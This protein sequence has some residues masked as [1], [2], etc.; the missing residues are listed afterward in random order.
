MLD[1]MPCHHIIYILC[2]VLSCC[3][4]SCHHG[5]DCTVSLGEYIAYMDSASALSDDNPVYIFETLVD[6]PRFFTGLR[7]SVRG[8]HLP[9]D[10]GD[11]LS[12]VRI[13]MCC[14]LLTA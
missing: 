9:G 2:H 6:V 1:A 10:R 7:H 3:V 12:E 8:C 5:V 13:R 14:V 4:V 11:L